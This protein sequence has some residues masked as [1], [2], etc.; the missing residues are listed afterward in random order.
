MRVDLSKE[1]TIDSSNNARNNTPKLKRTMTM[2]SEKSRSSRCEK[3]KNRGASVETI[4]FNLLVIAGRWLITVRH[5]G[6]KNGG[7]G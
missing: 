7:D 2:N 3:K 6:R 1:N 5:E 4:D